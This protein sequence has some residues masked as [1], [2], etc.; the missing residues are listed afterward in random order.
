MHPLT[1]L[2][3]SLSLAVYFLAVWRG[4]GPE[5][6][7]GALLLA[8]FVADEVR[9]AVFGPLRFLGFEP[10]QFAV[11]ALELAVF[12]VLAIRANRVWPL[13]AAALML[14]AVLGHLA[15]WIVPSGMTLAYWIMVEPPT[16][17]VIITLACGTAAHWRRQRRIGPYPDW[18]PP[19]APA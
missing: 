5:R 16:L 3:S 14:T 6:V 17:L 4:G 15:A 12:T 1:I 8:V 18:R 10:Y 19:P 7:A 9:A 13:V 11:N 2:I